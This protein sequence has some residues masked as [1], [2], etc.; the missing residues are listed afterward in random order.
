ML[1][2]TLLPLILAW[3]LIP[4]VQSLELNGIGSYQQLRKEFYIGALYVSKP[5]T[6]AATIR[7]SNTAKRMAL[8]VTSKRWS[9]RRWSLMWQNDIAINNSF[10][11]DAKLTEQLMLFTGFLDA[12]LVK[13]DEIIVDY[14]PADGTNVS[15]NGVSILKTQDM[16]FFNYL[17]NVW[18]GKL[19]PSGQFKT[20]VLGASKTNHE[21]LLN[22][23]KQ[24][25]YSPARS[26]VIASWIQARKD[27]ILAE[28]RK[29]EAAKR[30][31]A[32]AKAK[33]L[34]EAKA[35][36]IA[37]KKAKAAKQKTYVP[38]KK[39]ASN[40]VLT[41]QKKIVTEPVATKKEKTK[42]ER[43]AEQKYYLE[44]YHW[45]IVREV[46]KAVQY[47]EWA[48][49]FGQQGKV[50]LSFN[51]NRKAEVNNIT[52]ANPEVSDLLVGELKR[53][54]LA[55]VPFILPPDALRGDNWTL[56]MSYVFEPRLRQQALIKKPGKPASLQTV[57]KLSRAQY[58]EVL[59]R[60]IDDIKDRIDYNIEYPTWAKNLN[61]KGKVAYDVVLKRDGSISKVNEIKKT[62]HD[63]LNTE[64]ENAINDS[65]PYPAI[66]DELNLE[67]L[68]I[69]IRHS[70]K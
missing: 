44:L 19:P 6:D 9:P 23:F 20:D 30:K 58:K 2:K 52:G 33:K 14:T 62:R 4:S 43:A 12:N 35:K 29:K 53:A 51:V 56:Q 10:T 18:I 59:S 15:I 48:R 68:T 40:K 39:L 24:D 31:L 36:A 27:A 1:L 46:R 49:N 66:P 26:Q 34:A 65:I 13:G 5:S 54:I 8:K 55:I 7:N 70:F 3:T 67:E 41:K 42:E 38:S 50:T 25:D 11:N 57:T 64:V 16:Q 28:Q 17:L 21:D 47:P 32:E 37:A 45:E 69:S 61:Q 60:Y 22:R 63:L